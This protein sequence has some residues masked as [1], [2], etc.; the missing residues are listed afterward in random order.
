LVSLYEDHAEEK[1]PEE[2]NFWETRTTYRLPLKKFPGFTPVEYNT[3]PVE[4][5]DD[6]FPFTLLAETTLFHFGGGSRSSRSSRL[7]KYDSLFFVRINVADAQKM[8]LHTGE[9]V[10]VI[11]P[12]GQLTATVEITDTLPEGVV[13]LPRSRPDRPAVGLFSIYR[14]AE[15]K[16]PAFKTCPVRI[17]RSCS[18]E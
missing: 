3:P 10:R 8:R 2:E 16:T 9:Q 12:V 7:G 14:A 17:E 4:V 15:E 18:H 6:E 5:T 1:V 11:S 13:S